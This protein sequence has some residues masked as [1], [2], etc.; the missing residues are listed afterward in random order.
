MHLPLAYGTRRDC[1]KLDL[2]NT[3]LNQTYIRAYGMC[4]QLLHSR[5]QVEY[6]ANLK[7][8]GAQS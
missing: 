6:G 1:K 8:A 2:K 4:L 5:F 7:L 3:L